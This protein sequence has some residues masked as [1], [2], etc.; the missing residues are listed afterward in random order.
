MAD[1]DGDRGGHD[2]VESREALGDPTD[3]AVALRAGA[4]LFNEGYVLAAHDPWE[5]AWL[6]LEAGGDGGD[7]RRRRRATP[8]RTDRDRGR[9]PPRDRGELGRRGR[10]CGERG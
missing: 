4:A 6:P 8:P 5:A 9:N 7:R 2:L 10:L 3:I 1:D